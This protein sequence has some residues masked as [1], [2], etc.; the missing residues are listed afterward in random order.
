MPGLGGRL[1]TIFQPG[2]SLVILGVAVL[3][4]TAMALRRVWARAEKAFW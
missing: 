4:V 3:W 2:V 1:E